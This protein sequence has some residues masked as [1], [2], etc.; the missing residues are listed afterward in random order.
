M[1]SAYKWN[2]ISLKQIARIHFPHKYFDVSPQ[3]ILGIMT[4]GSLCQY[5]DNILECEHHSV[6]TA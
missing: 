6:A 1:G 4:A 2:N 3:G 5:S